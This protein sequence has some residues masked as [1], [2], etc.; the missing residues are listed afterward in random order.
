MFGFFGTPFVVVHVSQESALLRAALCQERLH[1]SKAS[2]EAQDLGRGLRRI[3][4]LADKNTTQMH[5]GASDGSQ[6]KVS[7]GH[8][9]SEHGAQLLLS[10]LQGAHLGGQRRDG[11]AETLV[12][13]LEYEQKNCC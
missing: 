10:G 8:L 13:L 7:S 4:L 11:G 6:P 12:L 1:V 3:F 9:Q 5:M 2:R